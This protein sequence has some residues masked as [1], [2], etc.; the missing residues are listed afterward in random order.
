MKKHGSSRGEATGASSGA[1]ASRS[2]A[3]ASRHAAVASMGTASVGAAAS[4]GCGGGARG[5]VVE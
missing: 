1:A 5:V 3:V 4:N 2:A